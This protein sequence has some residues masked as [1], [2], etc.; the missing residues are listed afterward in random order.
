MSKGEVMKQASDNVMLVQMD[1]LKNKDA[2]ANQLHCNYEK[3]NALNT[4][5]IRDN[6]ADY[7]A[8]YTGLKYYNHGH[9]GHYGH[10]GHPDV[11]NNLYAGVGRRDDRDGG[12]GRLFEGFAPQRRT[13]NYVLKIQIYYTF[14]PVHKQT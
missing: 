6:L 3:L 11:H 4:D 13:T 2:L 5:R 9:H 14:Y 7:R 10:H 12:F 8:E 1:A